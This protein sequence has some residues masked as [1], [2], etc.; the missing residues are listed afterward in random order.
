[1]VYSSSVFSTSLMCFLVMNYLKPRPSN[2]KPNWMELFWENWMADMSSVSFVSMSVRDSCVFQMCACRY[3]FIYRISVLQGA[4]GSTEFTVSLW[5]V[6][7]LSYL[8]WWA[9]CVLVGVC[10]EGDRGKGEPLHHTAA[11]LLVEKME[12]QSCVHNSVNIF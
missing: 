2:C 1:M 3:I 10:R 12:R 6:Q 7:N 11:C 5:S 9:P 8:T 4:L